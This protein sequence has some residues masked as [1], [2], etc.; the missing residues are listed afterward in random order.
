MIPALR[1][2]FG[3]L[4]HSPLLG[5]TAVLNTTGRRSGR[6]RAFPL[7][8]ALRDGDIYFVAGYGERSDWYRN[9]L[10]T[11]RVVVELPGRVVEGMA[12]VVTDPEE[13]LTAGTAVLRNT[14]FALFPQGLNPFTL[15]E[16]QVAAHD[17]GQHPVV[18]VRT[19]EPVEPRM[20]DP[21]RWGFLLP[22]VVA[23]V[24]ALV[25]LRKLRGR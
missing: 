4:L 2:W 8:Y 6:P 22:H 18:R 13:R 21:G 3:S 7:C 17:T 14:G 24:L 20:W 16:E 23:P 5:Y 1:S 25:L 11:P 10:A 19:F 9:L 12:E 15:T